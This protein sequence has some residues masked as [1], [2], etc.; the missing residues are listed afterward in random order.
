M[1]RN[2]SCVNCFDVVEGCSDCTATVCFAC[3][4]SY[5]FVN[6][7]LCALPCASAFCLRCANANT[8]L[9]FECAVGYSLANGLCTLNAAVSVVVCGD[10]VIDVGEECDDGNLIDRDGCDSHCKVEQFYQ[11]YSNTTA[12]GQSFT[13]YC[14]FTAPIDF[15]LIS[16][17][18]LSYSNA[19]RILIAVTHYRERFWETRSTLSNFVVESPIPY[20]NMA[21]AFLSRASDSSVKVGEKLSAP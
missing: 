10:L 4:A 1:L 20:R 14:A 11:C 6:E 7:T 3:N 17:E 16:I 9:C 18:K 5:A 15:T 2:G 8:S 13:N 12:L 19:L 21:V